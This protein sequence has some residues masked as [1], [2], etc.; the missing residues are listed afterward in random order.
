MPCGGASEANG[1]RQSRNAPTSRDQTQ[2]GGR[3]NEMRGSGVE[4]KV[5]RTQKPPAY[6]TLCLC[7]SRAGTLRRVGRVNYES[8]E[9][10]AKTVKQR[11]VPTQ[12]H[13]VR[14][15]EPT[16]NIYVLAIRSL[17]DE[18]ERRGKSPARTCST[19]YEE[20]ANLPGW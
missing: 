1:S 18:D 11:G 15:D 2:E 5:M 6:G 10:A 4:E 16:I 3:S 13:N 20:A 12:C 8:R 19:K 7:P 9:G 17:Q 14:W